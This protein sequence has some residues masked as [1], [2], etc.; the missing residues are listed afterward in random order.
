MGGEVVHVREV[1]AIILAHVVLVESRPTTGRADNVFGAKIPSPVRP[2][3]LPRAFIAKHSA[4]PNGW[5]AGQIP[6]QRAIGEREAWAG[7]DLHS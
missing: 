2:P 3:G 4:E 5:G 6:S 7:H 1:L